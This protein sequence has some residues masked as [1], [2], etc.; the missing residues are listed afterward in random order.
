[1]NYFEI[2]EKVI[3]DGIP[4][5]IHFRLVGFG[6]VY[7]LKCVGFFWRPHNKLSRHIRCRDQNKLVH[8][9]YFCPIGRLDL[10][11]QRATKYAQNLNWI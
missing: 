9:E 7:T 8:F 4:D 2:S 11:S 10:R 3:T 5:Y 1:M 6:F